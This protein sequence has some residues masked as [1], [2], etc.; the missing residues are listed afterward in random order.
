MINA[1][2]GGI[3]GHPVQLSECFWAQAEEEGLRCGQQMVNDKVKTIIFGFVTVGNQ[4]IYAT[5]KGTIP[6]TGVITANAADPTA[7]NAYFLN[8]S[9]TTGIGAFGTYTKRFHPNVKTAAVVYPTDPGAITAAA[10]VKKGLQQVGVK[11]TMIGIP[12]LATDLIGPATQASSS[13]MIVAALG[14]PTCTPF[15]RAIDQIHYTKPILSTPICTFIPQVA[16]ASGDIPKWTYGLVQTLVNLPGPQ[17]K[18]YLKKGLQYGTNVPDMLW[19][20]SEGAWETLLATVKIMNAIPYSKLTPATISARVQGLPRPDHPGPAEYRLRQGVEGRACCMRQPDQ[21]LQLHGQGQVEDRRD[22]AEAAGSEVDANTDGRWARRAA[23]PTVARTLTAMRDVLLYAALGLGAGALIA[24]VALGVVLI[25]RGSGIINLATGAIA[26]LAAYLYWAFKTGYFHFHLS[27]VPA[28]ALTLVCMAVFGVLI[29][30]AIFRPLRNT[31]PLAKLAASLGL[32]LVLESGVILIFGN[33]LKSAPVGPPL[34]HGDGLRP[35]RAAGPVPARRDRDRRRG[36]AGGA[37]SVDAVRTVDAGGVGERGLGHARRALAEPPGDREHRARERRR[38]RVSASSLRR[39]S[40]STRRRLPSRSFRHSQPH[41]SRASRR[42]SSRALRDWPSASCSRS[43]STGGRRA[44][45]RQTRAARRS[46]D[47][48]SSSSFSSSFSRSSCGARACPAGRARREAAPGST[49]AG[50]VAEAERDRRDRGRRRADRVP[51]RLQAVP[52]QLV[53]GHRH[54][55]VARRHRRL[56]RPDLGRAA[57]ARRCRGLHD[58]APDD[59]CRGHLGGVPDLAPD[60]RP[61]GH[62]RRVAD[63]G[64]G[65]AGAGASASWS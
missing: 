3:N 62:R 48:P 20:F 18:L 13:D 19:V 40:R 10:A 65:P 4:S 55:P 28:F 35:N 24:S 1:E 38:R 11:V 21:L 61:R 31:A 36:G 27:S 26:M 42:S 64:V 37:L 39:S 49:Q 52:D 14:F 59:G 47:C 9:Q 30:L 60:R 50:A 54:L 63:R 17:S 23:G 5:V 6:I 7:K 2:L 44:G 8:G 53:A 12:P 33:S 34:G 43:S 58:V 32:L 25:Y 45:S 41:C 22:L 51:V 16:Y 57:R 15:A 56:R 46:A 29:E